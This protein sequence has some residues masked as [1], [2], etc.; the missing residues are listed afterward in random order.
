MNEHQKAEALAEVEKY[1]LTCKTK[2]D[3]DRAVAMLVEIQS[4]YIDY[5]TELIETISPEYVPM[6]QQ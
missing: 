6:E 1:L 4:K 3:V 2:A 5:L